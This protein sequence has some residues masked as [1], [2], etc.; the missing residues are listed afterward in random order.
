MLGGSSSLGHHLYVKGS[1][2]DYNSWAEI[3][4]E[5]TW[6]YENL[7]PYFK[8][9]ENVGLTKQSYE[10]NNKYLKAFKEAGHDI[11]KD[12]N[13]IQTL[14]YYEPTFMVKGGFRQ[15]MAYAYLTPARHRPN[16]HVLKETEVIEINFDGNT[17]VGVTAVNG[18][19]VIKTKAKREVIVS[20]G[21]IKSPHLLMLSGIGPKDHLESNGIAVKSKLPVGKTY[22]DHLSVILAHKLNIR[23]EKSTPKSPHE[24]PLPIVIGNVALSKSQTFPDYQTINHIIPSDSDS[25]LSICSVE[26]SFKDELCQSIYNKTKGSETILTKLVLLHPKSRGHIVLESNKYNDPPMIISGFLSHDEDLDSIVDYIED[27]IKVANTKVFKDFDA[28]FILPDLPDCNTLMG[29]FPPVGS[30]YWKC[31]ILSMMDASY[32][33]S[34]TCSMGTVVDSRLRVFGIKGLR[35]IDASVIPLIPSGNTQAAVMV[36]AE[37]GAA[38]ILEDCKASVSSSNC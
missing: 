37:K 13:G 11:L 33:Y 34:S 26:Y 21:A 20:A 18:N 8:K 27:F 38:M 15:S 19:E 35:V 7:R 6:N 25:I 3:V 30:T 12:A 10:V 2:Y 36:I 16:L 22:Q 9:F 1:P 4:K 23:N 24:I 17:A 32:H 28:Q 14:G 29:Y 5:N 31:Y